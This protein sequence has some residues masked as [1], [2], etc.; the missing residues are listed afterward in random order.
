V[1]C[2]KC[3]LRGFEQDQ[4]QE[5]EYEHEFHFS[6]GEILIQLSSTEEPRP[7]GPDRSSRL[8]PFCRRCRGRD[9]LAEKFSRTIISGITDLMTGG[10]VAENDSANHAL[11]FGEMSFFDEVIIGVI[12]VLQDKSKLFL[13]PE[14]FATKEASALV[15]IPANFLA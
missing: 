10:I 6:I 4:D 12:F 7:F 2:S 3:K 1:P 13:W 14:N 5:H 9:R 8:S 11:V 15:Q